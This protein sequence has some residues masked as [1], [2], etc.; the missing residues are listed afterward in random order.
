M[1]K[2]GFL[3]SSYEVFFANTQWTWK[4]DGAMTS[5]LKLVDQR[6]QTL[7]T[8]DNASWSLKKLGTLTIWGEPPLHVLDAIIV[9]GLGRIEYQR[10]AQ[11]THSGAILAQ[12]S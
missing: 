8:F 3:S 9:S 2:C 1:K 6:D 4:R 7:A 11:K 12:A 5:N 10:R